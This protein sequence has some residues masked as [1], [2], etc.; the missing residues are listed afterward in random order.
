VYIYL[1]GDESAEAVYQMTLERIPPCPQREDDAE[2]NDT[3]DTATDSAPGDLDGQLC[4]GDP[5]VYAFQVKDQESVVAHLSGRFIFGGAN[6]TIQ[7]ADGRILS[8]GIPL[9]DG[10]MALGPDLT[11]GTYYVRVAGEGDGKYDLKVQ[12]LPPC[13]AGNDTDETNDVPN[14][15]VA[16]ELPPPPQGDEKP[17]PTRRL[18]RICPKDVD[19][20]RIPVTPETPLLAAGIS[21]VHDKSDLQLAE[22]EADGETVAMESDQSSAEKNGEA[23]VVPPPE[24]RIPDPTDYLLRVRGATDETQGFYILSLQQLPP[25]GQDGQQNPNNDQQE[26]EED[27]QQDQQQDQEQQNQQQQNQQQD[28]SE[29]KEKEMDRATFEKEMERNDDQEKRNLEAEKAALE[30][31]HLRQPEKDW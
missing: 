18:N 16:L 7:A 28:P 27:Q 10:L 6:L 21:F 13:P 9:D 23:V 8:S 2:D 31:Q 20:F 12:V 29:G 1:A 15:A 19:W 4:P 26:G 22:Y 24:A 14:D 25:S 5:D 3:L 11:A 30:A 17:E